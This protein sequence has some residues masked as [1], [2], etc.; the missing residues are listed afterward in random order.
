MKLSKEEFD[1]RKARAKDAAMH[2][3]RLTQSFRNVGRELLD[4]VNFE[5]GYAWP[6]ES[7]VAA[8][9]G[10]DVR[11]VKRAVKE[12]VATG[13]FRIAHEPFKGGRRNL[14]HPAFLQ[15]AGDVLSPA[16]AAL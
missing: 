2:D 1:R 11:T 6:F 8:A 9:L 3:R 12:L 4:N 13:Y 15:Q 5:R 14:Y 16:N 10:L 7:T